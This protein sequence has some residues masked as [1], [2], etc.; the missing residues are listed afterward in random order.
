MAIDEYKKRLGRYCT[1][2]IIETADET[3]PDNASDKEEQMIRDKEGE[4]LAAKLKDNAY[5]IA[6]GNQRQSL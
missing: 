6:M 5:V 4:R 3:T 2:E 1:L